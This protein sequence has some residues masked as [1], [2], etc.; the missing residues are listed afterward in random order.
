MIVAY[1]SLVV[2]PQSQDSSLLAFNMVFEIRF[3]GMNVAKTIAMRIPEL[4]AK[5][6]RPPGEPVHITIEKPVSLSKFDLSLLPGALK[7]IRFENL[8]ASPQY[9]VSH[10]DSR[11]IV[12]TVGTLNLVKT[13]ADI[14]AAAVSPPLRRIKVDVLRTPGTVNVPESV[15]TELL[16]LFD[17][18][19]LNS[20]DLSKMWI[21]IESHNTLDDVGKMLASVKNY[22][23]PRAFYYDPN[24]DCGGYCGVCTR[25]EF[26]E[27]VPNDGYSDDGGD[28]G[29]GTEAAV[30]QPLRLRRSK[31]ARL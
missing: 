15:L 20:A 7:M 8:Y 3:T 14:E 11:G 6:K 13:G 16:K 28:G 26:I 17:M 18:E 2:R 5:N 4:A 10:F 12:V 25:C 9:L 24:P 31:R 21:V 22:I 1:P 23:Q 30:A 29:D 19:A 27:G